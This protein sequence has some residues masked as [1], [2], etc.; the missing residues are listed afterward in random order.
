MINESY[1]WFNDNYPELFEKYHGRYLLIGRY[2]PSKNCE[3]IGAYKSEE[4][5]ACE[6]L[7]QENKLYDSLVVLC[8]EKNRTTCNIS[9]PSIHDSK[10]ILDKAIATLPPYWFMLAGFFFF[11]GV[12]TAI[13][14]YYSVTN[15]YRVANSDWVIVSIIFFILTLIAVTN[16]VKWSIKLTTMKRG[17]LDAPYGFEMRAIGIAVALIIAVFLV[18]S[19]VGIARV[20]EPSV[21][22]VG[23]IVV[24]F[25]LVRFTIR[26]VK[27]KRSLF[28]RDD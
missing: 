2:S 21:A 8:V 7:I 13:D 16:G 9:T 11:G 5:A 10:P 4:E 17:F 1:K 23:A 15:E 3:V 18:C 25:Y 24:I 14:Y 20:L 22:G 19:F 28:R 26:Y 27:T 6:K 12:V